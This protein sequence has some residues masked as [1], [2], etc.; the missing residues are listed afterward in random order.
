MR[1]SLTA[2]CYVVVVFGLTACASLPNQQGRLDEAQSVIPK[3]W[4]Y[5]PS[6]TA[7]H[8]ATQTGIGAEP[9]SPMW[10][11]QVGDAALSDL[12]Q[13]ALAQNISLAIAVKRVEQARTRLAQAEANA[14]PQAQGQVGASAQKNLSGGAVN[15]ST[16][17]SASVSWEIDL[18]QRLAAQNQVAQWEAVATE[19]DRQGV[20]QSLVASVVRGYWQWAYATERVAVAKANLQ[21]ARQTL[22][23]LEAQYKAGAISGLARTQGQQVVSSQMVSLSQAQATLLDARE[24]LALL[25]GQ[26][27]QSV[28][29]PSAVAL[30]L[31][32]PPALKAGLPAS[33]LAC[34]PDVYAAQ[35]RLQKAWSQEEATA[36]QWYPAL[37]LTGAV[38]GS[39]TTVSDVLRDPLGSLSAALTLPFLQWR[40]LARQDTLSQADAE[41]AR[42]NFHD[43]LFKALS[44]ADKNMTT[45]TYLQD[46]WQAQRA[47]LAS[48]INVERMTRVRYQAGAEPL[49]VLLDAQNTLRQSELDAAQANVN[50]WTQWTDTML[51]LGAGTC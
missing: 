14:W 20:A 18:W 21:N 30:P 17:A 19:A 33:V 41:I 37:S 15:R 3:A 49:R 45:Q 51:S 8:A 22:D 24:T 31:T 47:L 38:S 1:Y 11:T 40:E 16:S 35:A 36:R 2:I 44:E 13:K 27:P 32:A 4:L 46:Q 50:M 48:A 34:R 26:A 12:V 10:W 9:T 23:L 5:E 28:T 43:T 7:T 29:L 39:A 6:Q 42:L 25:M